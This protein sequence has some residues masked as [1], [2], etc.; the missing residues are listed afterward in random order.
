MAKVLVVGS[1]GRE[2]ALVRSFE[3]SP[4]VDRLFAA[5]GNAGTCRDA[6]NVSI[7]AMDIADLVRFASEN[8]IDLTVFGSEEPLAAGA[9]D[10]FQ[11]AGL[12]VFG[13][14]QQATQI[15]SSK[16][17][18]KEAM[19]AVG[20]RTP[21]FRIFTD[22]REALAHVKER[23]VPVVVK[24]SGLALGKGSYVCPTFADAERAL[25][26]IM[27]KRIHGAAGDAVVIERVVSGREVSV[28]AI[29]SGAQAVMLPTAHDYKRLLTGGGGP[30]TG[31]MGCVA[32]VPWVDA[33][34]LERVRINTVLPML[35]HLQSTCGGFTGC[36]YPGMML[37]DLG[38]WTLE[39]NARMGDPETEVIL[40]LLETDTFELFTAAIAGKLQ[41]MEVKIRSDFAVCVT[42]ASNGYGYPEKI[43]TGFDIYGI[44]NA[45]RITGV[46]VLH[47]ST[48]EK[49]GHPVTAGGRVLFVRAVGETL[50][51]AR[52]RAYAAVDCISFEGM[53]L[54]TDIGADC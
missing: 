44:E 20:I 18:A 30:N 26:A 25:D 53:Q 42:L 23:G 27:V 9:A 3:H 11:R 32:P 40:P 22:H 36:L 15:E 16:A 10:A 29:C 48:A 47:G 1:G 43:A 34:F 17:W 31:G 2:H 28:H 19:R 35:H 8:R 21:A 50:A 33:Q 45:E 52:E 38:A 12:P 46:E 4:N 13:P 49:N 39:F 14:T 51:Q 54:R 37:D 41:G 5:P 7:K 24:A 6:E